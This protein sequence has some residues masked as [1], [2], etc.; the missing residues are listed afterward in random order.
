MPRLTVQGEGTFDVEKGKRLVLAIE[1]NGVDILH[2]CGGYAKCTTCRVDFTDGEPDQMT[3][4]EKNRLDER[5]LLGEVRLSCQMYC[6]H[7]MTVR[8]LMR[9]SFGDAASPGTRPEDEV[10]PEPEWIPAVKASV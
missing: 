10:T 1:D 2:R 6:N 4:A 7:D 9:V 5:D 3:V 8:P